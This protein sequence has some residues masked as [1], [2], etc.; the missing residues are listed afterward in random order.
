MNLKR[1]ISGPLL[2]IVFLVVFVYLIAGVQ[3]IFENSFRGFDGKEFLGS[4]SASVSNIP[5]EIVSSEQNK[6]PELIPNSQEFNIKAQS[7]ISVWTDLSETDKILFSINEQRKLSIASLSKLMTALIVIENVDLSQPIKISKEATI[8]CTNFEPI[9]AGEVFSASDLLYTMLIGSDNTAA[10]ALSEG[11]ESKPGTEKFVELMNNRAKELGLSDTSFLNTTGLG[12]DNFSTTQ[13]L[14]KLVKYFIIK[15]PSILEIT[16]MPEFDLYTV[17]GKIKHKII[18]TNKLLISSDDL[19][20]RIIGGKT[21]ETRT[22]GE[23]LL[24]V[25]KPL[26]GQG[27]LIN[28]ILNSYD[29]FAEMKKLVSWVDLNYK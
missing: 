1:V 8:Q 6:V 5:A 29:R 13:D 20:K 21:G 4:V 12:L 22:A 2:S 9:K 17:D 18:N 23:C 7:V 16:A 11:L 25:L 15:Y 19:S 28:V 14:A 24:L 3:W 10:Y 26:N 27:Y